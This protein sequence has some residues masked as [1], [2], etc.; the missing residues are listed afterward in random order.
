VCQ[1]AC[2]EAEE[3]EVFF[4]EKR[5]KKLLPVASGIRLNGWTKSQPHEKKFF[6]SFFQK[7]TSFFLSA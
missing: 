7:N 4:F 3:K 1:G 5:T 6:G 2:A